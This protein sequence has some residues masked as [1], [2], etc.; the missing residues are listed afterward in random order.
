MRQ[1]G[2][3]SGYSEEVI[4][5]YISRLESDK[6]YDITKEARDA[7]GNGW[8]NLSSDEQQML[9][10]IVSDKDVTALKLTENK[11]NGID[12]ITEYKRRYDEGLFDTDKYS[13]DDILE[14]KLSKSAGTKVY[15]GIEHSELL[16][17]AD[18]FISD[19]AIVQYVKSLC[20]DNEHLLKCTNL[21]EVADE[22]SRNPVE[23]KLVTFQ[24]AEV[25]GANILSFGGN[26]GDVNTSLE[27]GG[28]IFSVPISKLSEYADKYGDICSYEGGVFKISDYERFGQEV[29][30]GVPLNSADGAYM[31]TTKVPLNGT[32][33][34]MPSVNSWSAYMD[35]FVSGGRLLSG[36]VEVTQKPLHD[37]ISD[38]VSSGSNELSG[39]SDGV[40]YTISIMR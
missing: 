13:L 29:L 11:L 38:A 33:I 39:I 36:E 6:Q 16:P 7:W 32:N 21:Q 22:L 37:I 17:R 24:N 30:S 40:G 9:K 10:D 14:L 26:F 20:P 27:S 3:D 15:A 12:T 4:D 1:I 5:K 8:D 31:I 25:N 28:G 19:D 35:Q 34:S 18:E 2:K 23:L